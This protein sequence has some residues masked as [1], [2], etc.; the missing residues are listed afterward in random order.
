M[1]FYKAKVGAPGGYVWHFFIYDLPMY[2]KQNYRI[3]YDKK[4]NRYFLENMNSTII[5]RDY[6][7]IIRS[8]RRCY[9]VMYF[10]KE[11]LAFEHGT[12]KNSITCAKF[13]FECAVKYNETAESGKELRN[14]TGNLFRGDQWQE[15]K[16]Q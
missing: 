3:L 4:Y 10:N 12:F 6:F 9:R 16:R 7:I 1:D 5:K 8:S 14:G 2:I 11:F 13:V 15:Q